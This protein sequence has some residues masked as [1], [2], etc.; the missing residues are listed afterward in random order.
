MQCNSLRKLEQDY[1]F[2][3][4]LSAAHKTVSSENSTAGKTEDEDGMC[5]GQRT[6]GK[7]IILE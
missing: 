4:W 5:L 6:G 1:S 2:R 7:C 3:L